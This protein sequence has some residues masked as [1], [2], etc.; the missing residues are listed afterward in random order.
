[1]FC[2]VVAVAVAVARL[3][4]MRVWEGEPDTNRFAG[5][6]QR[7]MLAEGSAGA[8]ARDG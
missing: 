7:F 8:N 1:M 4:R 6:S 2:G 3:L 5:K